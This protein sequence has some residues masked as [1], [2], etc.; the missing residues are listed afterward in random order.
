MTYNGTTWTA[1]VNI[2]GTNELAS[3]SCR[4]KEFCV[5]VDSDRSAI[6]TQGAATGTAQSI[7]T[8]DPYLQAV[9][10]ATT[11]FCVAIDPGG[12]YMVGR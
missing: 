12:N 4:S 6:Q 8:D 5:S 9:S 3:V 2:D 7:D 11:K 10:C 1:P